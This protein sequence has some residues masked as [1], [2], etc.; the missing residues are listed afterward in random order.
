[1]TDHGLSEQI[2]T[3]TGIVGKFDFNS[4]RYFSSEF[5]SACALI[6]KAYEL[7]NEGVIYLC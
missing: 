4:L 2:T 5:R 6:A 3:G 7:S 1:M